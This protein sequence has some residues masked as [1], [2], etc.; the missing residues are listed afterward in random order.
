M[1]KGETIIF[2]KKVKELEKEYKSIYKKS[3]AI[4]LLL[5]LIYLIVLFVTFPS[6]SEAKQYIV[7][8]IFG[9]M[10]ISILMIIG[11]GIIK[12]IKI[13][14][15]IVEN[16]VEHKRVLRDIFENK[17]DD[18]VVCSILE[19]LIVGCDIEYKEDKEKMYKLVEILKKEIE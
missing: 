4:S 2:F 7:P 18:A 13:R 17:K 3:L 19:V 14:E 15:L 1:F 6:L 5:F 16:L 9:I 12:K 8:G 11:K 10:M